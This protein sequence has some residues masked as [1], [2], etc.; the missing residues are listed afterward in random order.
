MSNSN[1]RYNDKDLEGVAQRALN[2]IEAVRTVGPTIEINRQHLGRGIDAALRGI[3]TPLCQE[4]VEKLKANPDIVRGALH[5]VGKVANSLREFPEDF[6]FQ[7]LKNDTLRREMLDAVDEAHYEFAPLMESGELT[8]QGYLQKL[9]AARYPVM[10]KYAGEPVASYSDEEMKIFYHLYIRV[11]QNGYDDGFESWPAFKGDFLLRKEQKGHFPKMLWSTSIPVGN[12]DGIGNTLIPV[13]EYGEALTRKLFVATVALYY[14]SDK[15][16]KNSARELEEACPNLVAKFTARGRDGESY[17]ERPL[18]TLHEGLLSAMQAFFWL[19]AEKIEGCATPEQALN[20]IIETD[21]HTEL[22]SI[23][24]SS[25]ISPSTFRGDF[26]QG[27]VERGPDGNLVISGAA[28]KL[29]R[30]NQKK[31]REYLDREYPSTVAKQESTLSN[32][33]RALELHGGQGCPVS[34]KDPISGKAGNTFLGEAYKVVLDLM[35]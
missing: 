30:D 32:G 1:G 27:L 31:Y 34:V 22:A 9:E 5:H 2:I 12:L 18:V 25:L 35:N 21:L 28:R 4:L 13:G 33:D 20:E 17:T 19:A 15:F 29:L 8:E 16:L 23:L 26:I 10:R 7:I 24:S 3:F 11:A 14:L 6:F